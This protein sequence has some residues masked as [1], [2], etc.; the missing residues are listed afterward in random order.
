MHPGA[1]CAESLEVCLVM[2]MGKTMLPSEPQTTVPN[3]F[4]FDPQAKLPAAEVLKTLP[5]AEV[6][7]LKLLLAQPAEY[8]THPLLENGDLGRQ[9]FA[10]GTVGALSAAKDDSGVY[11]LDGAGGSITESDPER[12]AFLR[13][14]YCRRRVWQLLEQHDGKRLNLAAVHELLRWERAVQEIRGQL[15]RDNLPLVLA[16]AKRT[17]LRGVDPS[18]LISE[19]SLALLRAA[20]KFDC[21][22]GYKFSTYACRAILKSFSRVA[23][24]TSRYRGHFPTEFDPVLEK[25]NQLERR[26]MDVVGE[27]VDE[28]R[29]IL[30]DNLGRLSDVERQVIQARFALDQP[31]RETAKGKTLEQVG[32]LIGVT[33][34]RVRQIQNKALDKLKVALNQAVL[35]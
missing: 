33:K 18:D 13:L 24:R 2:E 19:G 5:P 14:N 35:A 31:D 34:E 8:V 16:M 17:R 32:E 15:V 27:C 1:A 29:A 23:T 30:D 4:R 12:L 25:G 9:L 21:A 22:R 7:M 11:A 26:R 10:D 20:N 6:K 3:V 28:L